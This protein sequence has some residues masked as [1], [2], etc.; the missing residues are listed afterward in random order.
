[1]PDN[2]PIPEL[3]FVR[4]LEPDQKTIH[5]AHVVV[6]QIGLKTFH[7]CPIW[8]SAVNRLVPVM[9]SSDQPPSFYID[10]TDP[11]A[12]EL[13]SASTFEHRV[14]DF[15][16]IHEARDNGIVR[17]VKVASLTDLQRAGLPCFRNSEDPSRIPLIRMFV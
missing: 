6:L 13:W 7:F 11:F 8:K 4:L 17:I 5:T 14:N 3:G 1:M 2:K 10:A 12:Y 9:R 15:N 16:A